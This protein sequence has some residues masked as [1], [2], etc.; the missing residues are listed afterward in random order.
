MVSNTLKTYSLTLKDHCA[1]WNTWVLEEAGRM[2]E[3]YI[4]T[5]QH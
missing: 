1:V 3:G 4:R 5:M 2:L